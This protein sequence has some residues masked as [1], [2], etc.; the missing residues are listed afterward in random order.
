MGTP[1]H[2]PGPW[3]VRERRDGLD[4][5]EDANGDMVCSMALRLRD[6]GTR[7]HADCMLI[8]LAA[9]EHFKR[10]ERASRKEVR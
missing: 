1:L 8:V 6:D 7:G 4:I 3:R 10:A 2:S 5:I 9:N